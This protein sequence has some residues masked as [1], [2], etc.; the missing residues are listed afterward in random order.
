MKIAVL[1]HTL[2]PISQPYAGGMEMITHLLV[3]KLVQQGH[4]VH[5]FAKTGSDPALNVIPYAAAEGVDQELE[6]NAGER[7]EI[8]QFAQAA[9][10]IAQGRY[11]I[12]HNNSQHFLPILLGEELDVPVITTFHIPVFEFIQYAFKFLPGRP[13]QMFTCVSQSLSRVYAEHGIASRT[14]YNGIDLSAWHYSDDPVS[15][16][17][18]WFGRICP[19]KGT[20]HAIAIAKQMNLK[21]ILAG[22][23]SNKDYY[24][25]CIEQEL[26]DDQI[27]YL[28]HLDHAA[29]NLVIGS[30]RATLFLSTWEEPY[31]LAIAESLAC[32]T[33]VV[34]WDKG[35][36]SELLTAQCGVLVPAY[37][38]ALLEQGVKRALVLD[39][40]KCRARTEHFCDAEKMVGAYVELYEQMLAEAPRSAL[41]KLMV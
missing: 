17:L 13:K 39:R 29:L 37:D 11:D 30:C 12:V 40:K 27:T 7:L 2:H 31:G 28:G 34:A 16:A 22:P 35:A 9:L 23:I 24:T 25:S 15:D 6:E 38:M 18:L 14:I 33:P 5:L 8:Y 1:A 21:L 19:E 20:H 4:V 36:A 41:Q 3:K 10:K 26:D 32:G